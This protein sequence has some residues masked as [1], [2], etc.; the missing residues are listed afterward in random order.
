MEKNQGYKTS[1]FQPFLTPWLLTDFA[2]QGWSFQRKKTL[3]GAA[4]WPLDPHV[5][6]R[7]VYY[8]PPREWIHI[9]PNGK[10]GKSSSS[11]CRFLG[12]YVSVP[13]RVY[14]RWGPPYTPLISGWNNDPSHRVT[15]FLCL[16]MVSRHDACPSVYKGKSLEITI[17]LRCFIAFKNGSHLMIPVANHHA[18]DQVIW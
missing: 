16:A 17:G 11:K 1:P 6:G 9:P 8:Y 10:F 7:V 13:W 5:I 15:W 18:I 3:E 2:H 14:K 4:P 12:G